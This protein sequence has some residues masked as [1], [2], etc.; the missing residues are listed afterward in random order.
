M[1]TARCRDFWESQFRCRGASGCNVLTPACQ[2]NPLRISFCAPD[3]AD[4]WP[5]RYNPSLREP[6]QEP[7]LAFYS[8]RRRR[9]LSWRPRLLD[10]LHSCCVQLYFF[11]RDEP[12]RHRLLGS[13]LLLLRWSRCARAQHFAATIVF[14][15]YVVNLLVSG[16][17]II[18]IVFAALLLA[19][20]RATSLA[21]GWKPDSEEAALPPRLNET[22]G[23]KFADQL[24]VWLW[25]KIRIPYYIFSLI[26]M[27]LVAL[28]L[29]IAILRRMR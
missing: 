18:G 12:P 1:T 4:A 11:N 15:F 13:S 20:L 3:H 14:I 2:L 8:E 16:P 22:W 23:D 10:L 27:L 29:S 19:N 25:P 21:S 26:F 9:R 17:S 28:G 6:S 5:L 7:A 24:P